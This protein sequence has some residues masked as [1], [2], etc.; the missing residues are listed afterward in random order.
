MQNITTWANSRD[1]IVK[2]RKYDIK[3]KADGITELTRYSF[4]HNNRNMVE[5]LSTVIEGIDDVDENYTRTVLDT[6]FDLVRSNTTEVGKLVI[7]IS[8]YRTYYDVNVEYIEE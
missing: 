7:K 3:T 1:N 4:L 8:S 2:K 6:C 5:T